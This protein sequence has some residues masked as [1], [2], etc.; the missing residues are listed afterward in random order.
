MVA[1]GVSTFETACPRSL[2]NTSI[3]STYTNLHK[4]LIASFFKN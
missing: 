1:V 3:Q 2:K 4:T